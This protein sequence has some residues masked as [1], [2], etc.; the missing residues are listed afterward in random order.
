MVDLPA[1]DACSAY[2][3]MQYIIRGIPVLSITPCARKADVAKVRQKMNMDRQ[4]AGE[5][6]R[7]RQSAPIQ[8]RKFLT[9]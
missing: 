9:S 8:C 3:Y 4:V 2:K 5:K 6:A 1:A 7:V